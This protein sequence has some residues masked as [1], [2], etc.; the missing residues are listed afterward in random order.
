MTLNGC[1]ERTTHGLHSLSPHNILIPDGILLQ[2][3]QVGFH[4]SGMRNI[5]S[6]IHS[7]TDYI[8]SRLPRTQEI[9][10]KCLGANKSQHA[11]KSE[12]HDPEV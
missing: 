1:E 10:R 9:L 5:F 4:S 11:A 8:Q 12:E 6:G 7:E 3:F 2:R